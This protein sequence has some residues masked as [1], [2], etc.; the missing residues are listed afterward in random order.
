MRFSRYGNVLVALLTTA[1]GRYIIKKSMK[2][3]DVIE[4]DSDGYW[5]I[6]GEKA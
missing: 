6:G 2:E 3:D 5:I 4:V 1:L